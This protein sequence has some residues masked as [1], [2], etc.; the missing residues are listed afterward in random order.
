MFNTKRLQKVLLSLLLLMVS[1]YTY[2][3]YRTVSQRFERMEMTTEWY[4]AFIITYA[5]YGILI[6]EII[7]LW[8]FNIKAI[9]G[10]AK[11]L[12]KYFKVK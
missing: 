10:G 8:Y 12:L 2:F 7:F 3:A 6:F 9:C 5:Y 11:A 4:F 1:A